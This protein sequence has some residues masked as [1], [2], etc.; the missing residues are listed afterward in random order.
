[1]MLSLKD[2]EFFQDLSEDDG[3]KLSGGQCGPIINE[4]EIGECGSLSTLPCNFVKTEEDLDMRR[5]TEI[6]LGLDNTGAE[7]W[8]RTGRE[9]VCSWGRCNLYSS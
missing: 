3:S 5:Y 4:E 2:R 9:Y 8:W 7:Y 6:C 1:M